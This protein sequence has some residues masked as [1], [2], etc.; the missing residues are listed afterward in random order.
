MLEKTGLLSFTPAD[1]I[2]FLRKE[3]ISK[4]YF[5][6]DDVKK[7][8]IASHTQLQS[9]ADY[10]TNDKR[11]FITHEG[12]FCKVSENYDMILGAFVHRTNRG[13]AAGGVRYWDYDTVEI[14]FP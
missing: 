10:F 9:I 14:L 3:N 7:S 6:Y 12:W 8:L 1:F 5:V 2:D 13:Q 4:F 11:D